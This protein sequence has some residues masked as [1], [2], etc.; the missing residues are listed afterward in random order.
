MWAPWA[1]ALNLCMS[2]FRSSGVAIIIQPRGASRLAALTR[3]STKEPVAASP[4]ARD[5]PPAWLVPTKLLGQVA[6]HG[7]H[8]LLMILASFD[9]L[10][11]RTT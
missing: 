3:A 2:L 8:C 6:R 7:D 9:T 11:S 4:A 1:S 5:K 10:K